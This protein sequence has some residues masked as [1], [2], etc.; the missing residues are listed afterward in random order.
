M[1]IQDQG[2]TRS[3]TS[4]VPVNTK[5]EPTGSTVPVHGDF[6]GDGLADI[7]VYQPSSGEWYLYPMSNS[8][9]TVIQWGDASMTPVPGDYNGDGVFDL[10]LYQSTTGRWYIRSIQD[11][12]PIAFGQIWGDA[13]TDPV[14]G[15]FNG[16][17]VYD[18]AVYQRQTGNWYIRSLGPIGPSNPPI[19]FG[20]NWGGAGL[21]PVSGDFNGDGI[22]DL[23]VYQTSTGN[24]YI[25]SLGPIGP[26]NP[27]ISFGQNWGGPGL[28][29]I[30]GDYDGD[31]VSDM[32][33]YQRA[34]GNWYI[35]SLGPVGPAYP[36]ITFGQN[37]GDSSMVPVPGDYNGDGRDDL[38]V[39]QFTSGYWFIRSLGEGPPILFQF[40]WGQ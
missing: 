39:Y 38:S 5:L 13:G 24:W 14:S 11:G 35:R 36:P 20:Q 30:P 31:G 34:T 32:A 3:V 40:K 27:P 28:D 25:R 7:M 37:W 16:D 21:L 9:P 19:S 17:G 33:V 6:D 23:A 22:F 15:D 8:G 29:P 2:V 26:S 4:R 18:L 10:A 12:P 1:E